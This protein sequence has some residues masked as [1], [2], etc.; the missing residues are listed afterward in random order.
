MLEI[1]WHGDP[2][3][4]TI[5]F[6]F[7]CDEITHLTFDGKVEEHTLGSVMHVLLMCNKFMPCSVQRVEVNIGFCQEVPTDVHSRAEIGAGV[8]YGNVWKPGNEF[9]VNTDFFFKE[10]RGTFAYPNE[11]GLGGICK[12][13]VLRSD[14]SGSQ[15]DGF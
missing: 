1:G 8:W 4:Q 11:G 9:D 15:S 14:V 6:N 3:K 10:K 5:A 7:S 12:R 2:Y 13:I